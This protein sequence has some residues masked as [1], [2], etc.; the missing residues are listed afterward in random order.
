MLT[1]LAEGKGV[2]GKEHKKVVGEVE[3]EPEKKPDEGHDQHGGKQQ[4][5]QPQMNSKKGF[6]RLDHETHVSL[7]DDRFI[8]EGVNL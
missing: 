4:S 8:F 7:A 6:G 3:I 2:E 5:P 1:R